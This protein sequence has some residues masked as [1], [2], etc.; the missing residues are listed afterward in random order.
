MRVITGDRA[1][2]ARKIHIRVQDSEAMHFLMLARLKAVRVN[3]D[4][5]ARRAE[6]VLLFG[7]E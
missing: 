2:S 7:K 4:I 6:H 5:A 3:E 1:V